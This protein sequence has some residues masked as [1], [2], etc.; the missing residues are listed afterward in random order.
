[1]IRRQNLANSA[2]SCPGTG[3]ES[4]RTLWYGPARA[5][6]AVAAIWH[7]RRRRDGADPPERT[8]CG[9]HSQRHQARREAALDCAAEAL[10]G[11]RPVL[12]RLAARGVAAPA[13][14]LAGERDGAPRAARL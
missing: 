4:A 10:R 1:Q 6:P 5:R 9:A 2:L 11:A 3:P 12:A 14:R 8:R 7:R 13:F